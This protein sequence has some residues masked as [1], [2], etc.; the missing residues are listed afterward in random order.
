MGYEGGRLACTV[1]LYYLLYYLLVT[2]PVSR[3]LFVCVYASICACVA[4][5]AP[6]RFLHMWICGQGV[7]QIS[8]LLG[9]SACNAPWLNL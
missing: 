9:P 3:A 4:D 1:L 2:G 8:P 6:V 7:E 5:E